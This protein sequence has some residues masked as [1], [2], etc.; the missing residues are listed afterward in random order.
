MWK[1]SDY[2]STLGAVSGTAKKLSDLGFTEAQT[3]GAVAMGLNVKIRSDGDGI[4]GTITEGITGYC[5]LSAGK[6]GGLLLTVPAGT[7]KITL[8]AKNTNKALAICDTDG[9]TVLKAFDD[10]ADSNY[11]DHVYEHTFTEETKVYI[12]SPS[13]TTNFKA[14][15]IE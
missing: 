12:N 14:I 9:T 11:S 7:T 3:C 6:A 2:L 1:V 13:G 10:V 8:G 5:Q 4:S 15:K